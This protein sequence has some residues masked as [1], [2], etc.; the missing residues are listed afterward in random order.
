VYQIL[1]ERWT[2]PA[3]GQADDFFVIDLPDWA[4]ALALTPAHELVMV[5][6]FRFGSA[7][8]GWELPA[9]CVDPGEDPVAAARR[10]LYEESGYSGDAAE[11]LGV[12]EPNPALQRNQCHI[13]LVRDARLTGAGDPGAHEEFAVR[14]IPL[15]EVAAMA[16]D[17]RISH[18]IVHTALWFL[19]RHL[20]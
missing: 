2:H 7:R 20:R 15:A 13:V 16:A 8:L 6:Q 17:G 12:V 11:L 9:G 19:E 1:R 4:L 10:E 18:A 14:A 5:Q 3:R